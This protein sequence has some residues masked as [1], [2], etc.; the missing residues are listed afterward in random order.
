M[1]AQ[2]VPFP[3]DSLRSLDEVLRAHVLAVLTA[4]NGNRTVAARTLQIDRKTIYRMLL[5]WRSIPA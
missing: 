2:T 1:A 4:C 3:D 5:R